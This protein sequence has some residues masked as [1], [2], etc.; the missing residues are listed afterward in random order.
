MGWE[1]RA[2]VQGGEEE[3]SSSSSSRV[4]HNH[5]KLGA[6]LFYFPL[7]SAAVATIRLLLQIGPVYV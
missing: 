1:A 3:F 2:R 4:F 5:P 7:Q 6:L